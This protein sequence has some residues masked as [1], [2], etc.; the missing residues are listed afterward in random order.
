MLVDLSFA[1]RPPTALASEDPAAVLP[2]DEFES[3]QARG[4]AA[5]DAGRL[6][7]SIELLERA[8]AWAEEHGD[9]RQIDLGFCN[10]T[11]AQIARDEKRPLAPATMQR[12]R[13]VLLAS[14]DLTN[15]RLAAYNLARAF[16]FMSDSKKGL[17][18]ARIALDRAELLG[19]ADWIASSHNQIGNFLLADSYF[20]QAAAEYDEALSLYPPE[21]ALRRALVEGN[22]GYCS[23]ARG[24]V[25]QGLELLVRSFRVLARRGSMTD[26][27]VAHADL[28]YAHLELGRSRDAVR[29]GNKALALA[30]QCG[31]K[32]VAKNCL[33]LLGAA[34]QQGGDRQGAHDCYSQL[35]ERYYPGS[36]FVAEFLLSVD[37]RRMINLRAA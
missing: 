19:R 24:R 9:R 37:V 16:E 10:L 34:T 32:D 1:F 4:Q 35:Q 11:S 36:A 8:L 17:F 2:G 18:Y 22:L 33:Y 7:E 15:C 6:P 30:E 14:E 21:A 13:A 5:F 27:A 25:Q 23:I 28:C 12:L 3:L 29:H 26:L 31:A 20:D